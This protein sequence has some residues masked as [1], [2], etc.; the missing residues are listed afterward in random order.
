VAI[1]P[2]DP[3]ANRSR[4]ALL[5][6]GIEVLLQNPNASLTEV[7]AF[8]GVGRATLY[9]H[10]KTRDQLIHE[11]ALES[12]ALTDS[13]MEPIKA[14]NLK[15]R[16]AIEAMLFAVM[17]LADRFHFL[18]SLWNIVEDDLAVTEIYERQLEEL[19]VLVE[20][21][22]KAGS[23]KIEIKTIWIVTTIDCLIYAGWWIV[24]GGECDAQEAAESAVQT[25]FGGIGA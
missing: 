2:K 4:Q 14:Q 12:L 3:R 18:L 15:G 19:A 13:A 6:A 1:N 24:R 8:A 22:K 9:R 10:F 17:P 16:E 7:A 20:Q 21:G 5:E 23:I 11:L 25:L